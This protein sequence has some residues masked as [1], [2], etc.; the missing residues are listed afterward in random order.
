[1]QKRINELTLDEIRQLPYIE[2]VI[3]IQ[4]HKLDLMVRKQQNKKEL[5]R[6]KNRDYR[7]QRNGVE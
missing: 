4:R 7:L 2:R 6:L 3:A 1:M 5:K